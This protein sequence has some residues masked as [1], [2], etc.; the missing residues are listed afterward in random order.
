MSVR[1]DPVIGIGEVEAGS[2]LPALLADALVGLG[3]QT[4]DVLAVTQ[5]IVS[6]AEGRL[7]SADPR[8]IGPLIERES[9]EILARR[10]DLVITR[11][12]HGFVCAN[13]GI[14]ASN[15]PAGFLSLLPEDPDASAERIRRGVS[16]RLGSDLGVV[17][18][19]T[20][21]R[22][23]RT[24]VVEVAIGCA[25]L[26]ALVDLR[27]R[28]DRNGRTL[29]A[30]VVAVAD[31]VAA[32]AGLVMPK[33]AGIPAALVRGLTHDVS[34]GQR[35]GHAAELV[36]PRADDLFPTSPL[37][38][39]SAR[40]TIRTFGRGTVP[41]AAVEEAV[42]AAITAPAPHH[43]IPWLFIALRS[44]AARRRYLAG[45]AD[46][47]VADLE[48]DGAPEE[49]IRRRL[50]ASESVLG[51]A[52]L[53][54]VPAMRLRGAHAYPDPEREE[55]ERDM[56]LLSGGAGIENLLLA[57][58]AQGLGSAWISSS[59]FCREEARAALDLEDE[60]LPLGTVA[61]GP[62]PV[63]PPAP[64]PPRPLDGFLRIR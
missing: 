8:G 31:E 56:F 48:R 16:E 36:R 34:A 61:V 43:T 2:D 62:R 54:L 64:R 45:M 37:S 55:A 24:G 53:L 20:F 41:D 30:T 28:S 9:D 15:V 49:T 39:I 22:A 42:A 32:A 52:P 57:L 50:A 6:K 12:R 5:K 27:G 26:P 18:T 3:P 13:A 35:P 63:D 19:D 38:A 4:G 44:D 11:T 25:G 51:A 23:W 29:D 47:W 33:A 60:W 7:V 1:I 58:H 17:I 40:R 21:G 14:D 10:G 59:I 46:A